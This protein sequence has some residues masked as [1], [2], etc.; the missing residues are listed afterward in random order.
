MNGWKAFGIV[1]LVITL[2]AILTIGGCASD[3]FG[4]GAK[5]TTN[6][7]QGVVEKTM[8][9]DHILG[10]Y[11]SF[12]DRYNEYKTAVVNFNGSKV[13]YK[14]YVSS[15]GPRDKWTFEDKDATSRK[16]NVVIGQFNYVNDLAAKYNA[17]SEKVDFKLFKN[18]P[19]WVGGSE[20]PERL[21][22]LDP[23]AMEGL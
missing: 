16:F 3:W 14:N 4:W 1:V 23:N 17:D 7:I 20:V 9:S 10:T 19:E 5:V 22:T 6:S 18:L 11:H 15:L 21:E 12:R 2:S 8:D 13:A